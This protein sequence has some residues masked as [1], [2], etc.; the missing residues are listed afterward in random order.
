MTWI[1]KERQEKES[2]VMRERRDNEENR[3]YATREKQTE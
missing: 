2:K 1:D 3:K